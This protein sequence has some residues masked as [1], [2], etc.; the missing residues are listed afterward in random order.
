[1]RH[2]SKLLPAL[3]VLAVGAIVIW[4]ARDPL[5]ERRRTPAIGLP[6][7]DLSAVVAEVDRLFEERWRQ[8]KITPAQSAEPL[9]VLRRLTLAL[10]G[11][12]P[13]LEEIRTFEADQSPDRLARAAARLLADRRFADYFSE[14]LARA[15]VGSD[16]GAFVVFRRDMFVRW[17]SERLQENTPYHQVVRSMITG[18]GLWTGRPETNFVTAALANDDLDENKLAGKTA[19]AFLGQRIDCAQCHDH[20]FDHW[21]QHEFAGLAAFYGQTRV[22]IVGVEDKS[23]D[24]GRPVEFEVQDRGTLEQQVVPASVPCSTAWLPAD[25]TRRERLATWVTHPENRRFERAIA[26]RVWAL[27][28]GRAWYE[29][30]DGV[31]DPGD[32]RDLLDVLGADFRAHGCDLRRMI[33]VIA[34]SRPFQLGS[35]WPSG[36][37]EIECV[38]AD[39][40]QAPAGIKAALMAGN[41]EA[42]AATQSL[43]E[44]GLS[45]ETLSRFKQAEAAWAVFPLIR[46]RP[47][48]V[49][50]SIRQSASIQTA[51]YDAHWLFRAARLLQENE[52]LRDYGDLGEDELQDRGGTIPQRLLLLN[53]ERANET[54]EPKPINAAGRIAVMAS[55][56]RKCIEAA[57]L[58]CLTRRPSE[59]E[60]AHFLNRLMDKAG[61]ARERVIEDL[62]WALYNATEFSWNH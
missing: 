9:Q 50:G 8:E 30:V 57:Y 43:P 26:N 28:F 13:S 18:T 38:S 23:V 47:E 21:K 37:V 2:L 31:P 41:V 22:S 36:E 48:Q 3:I 53:G 39:L 54:A 33:C 56:S 35:E 46:L 5:A 52:F 32:E 42:G 6:A 60:Q 25:G 7:S 34:A 20:P 45:G 14:R 1:M 29:P 49:I 62:I 27:L 44:K 61:K 58:V 12:I 10:C 11:T 24:N 16:N 40:P 59:T 55:S 17:L 19:R 4:A 15:F 51:D